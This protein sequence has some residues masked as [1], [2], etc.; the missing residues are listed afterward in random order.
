MMPEIHKILTELVDY[1]I[2]RVYEQLEDPGSSA[3]ISGYTIRAIANAAEQIKAQQRERVGKLEGALG[4]LLAIVNDSNGVDGYHL[5]G[6]IA[7]WDEFE[8]EIEIAEAAL[9]KPEATD[10]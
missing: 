5:N 6:D 3:K 1:A 2:D 9:K 7:T 10:E 4:G 8:E